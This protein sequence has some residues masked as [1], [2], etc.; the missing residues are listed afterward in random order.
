VSG[1]TDEF[2]SRGHLLLCCPT[3]RGAVIAFNFQRGRENPKH[4]LASGFI[5]WAV[6]ESLPKH[7][8]DLA[9]VLLSNLVARAFLHEFDWK[10]KS[11]RL[12]ALAEKLLLKWTTG[13]PRS[14]YTSQSGKV[15]FDSVV[16]RNEHDC[17]I[18]D[19]KFTAASERAEL[20][21]R[22]PSVVSAARH[23]AAAKAVHKMV[24]A[25]GIGVAA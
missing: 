13:A 20:A 6:A 17:F 23:L 18:Q 12:E 15:K 1:L 2:A 7:R 5:R 25:R 21:Q 16:F 9:I 14:T 4:A 3:T 24:T 10:T 22:L 11:A 8:G 19:H